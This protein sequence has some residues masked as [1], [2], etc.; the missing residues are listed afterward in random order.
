MVPGCCRPRLTLTAAPPRPWRDG[1]CERPRRS[2]AP[3]GAEQGGRM[4]CRRRGSASA[5]RPRTQ[6]PSAITAMQSQC[7]CAKVD[8]RRAASV[9]CKRRG[10]SRATSCWRAPRRTTWRG[11]RTN[12]V[13]AHFAA[14][15]GGPPRRVPK[16]ISRTGLHH[17]SARHG[18]CSVIIEL[19]VRSKADGRR[20]GHAHTRR[21]RRPP[22][23]FAARLSSWRCC[24]PRE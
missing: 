14:N 19:L 23:H 18:H 1:G 22:L 9:V 16:R 13:T 15:K 4:H 3:A 20:H 7:W 17:S 10:S 5:P 12:S 24:W 21:G 11:P 6:R 8:E 2:G